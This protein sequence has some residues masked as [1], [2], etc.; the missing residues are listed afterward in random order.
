MYC[1]RQVQVVSL[2][3]AIT[4]CC[5][6]LLGMICLFLFTFMTFGPGLLSTSSLAPVRPCTSLF[7]FSQFAF[8]TCG[9]GLMCMS[10]FP[11][12]L[13]GMLPRPAGYELPHHCWP[14][15]VDTQA[16]CLLMCHVGSLCVNK[17][18][19]YC[20]LF[21]PFS[22]LVWLIPEISHCQLSRRNH[23]SVVCIISLRLGNHFIKQISTIVLAFWRYTVNYTASQLG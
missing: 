18:L 20:L 23:K 2:I 15:R 9:T 13:R 11:T 12:R 14:S 21:A 1:F 22:S 8:M 19:T 17:I 16:C 3:F 7:A 6:D 10:C 4:L 5:A